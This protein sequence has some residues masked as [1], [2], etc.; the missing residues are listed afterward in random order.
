MFVLLSLEIEKHETDFQNS[1][2]GLIDLCDRQQK[3][4]VFMDIIASLCHAFFFISLPLYKWDL[5]LM[6]MS[7]LITLF[8]LLIRTIGRALSI[9]LRSAFTIPPDRS[10]CA[11]QKQQHWSTYSKIKANR[12]D[13]VNKQTNKT[14]GGSS[15]LLQ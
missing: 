14:C 3:S 11:A 10:R 5:L 2:P 8:F 7:L 13:D 4:I 6:Q 15:T 9:V 12:V 1:N